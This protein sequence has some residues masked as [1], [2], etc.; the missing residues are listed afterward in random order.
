MKITE[1]IVGGNINGNKVIAENMQSVIAKNPRV[2][3]VLTAFDGEDEV[4]K[5]MNL[6]P[7]IVF[8][9]MQMPKKT[10]LEVIEEIQGNLSIMKKPKFILVTADRDSSL[11]VKARELGFDIV[12]KPISAESINEYINNFEENRFENESI[13]RK[14][15][16]EQTRKELKRKGFFKRLLNIK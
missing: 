13:E 3:K 12:Y 2:E 7:D 11:I 10:G 14:E 5:I 16:I 1:I 4:I 9:D 8:T 6:K 15:K